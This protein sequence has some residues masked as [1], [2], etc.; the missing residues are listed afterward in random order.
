MRVTCRAS[1]LVAGT[2]RHSHCVYRQAREPGTTIVQ[3]QATHRRGSG[4][5]GQ[6]RTEAVPGLCGTTHQVSLALLRVVFALICEVDGA[7][8]AEVIRM[9]SSEAVRGLRPLLFYFCSAIA[10]MSA[11]R[12]LASPSISRRS[13]AWIAAFRSLRY[14]FDALKCVEWGV[15]P[16]SLRDRLAL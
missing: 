1:Q 10:K 9:I 14:L 3:P 13:C 15:R 8:H 2:A 11:M 5:G 12:R 6:G 4:C 16:A 7:E